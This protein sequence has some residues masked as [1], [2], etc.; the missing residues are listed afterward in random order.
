MPHQVE[1]YRRL[2]RQ[3]ENYRRT[4]V[5]AFDEQAVVT[6][7]RL[8]VDPTREKLAYRARCIWG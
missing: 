2:R 7:Q 3:L 1:A 6:L 8:R 4:L 5:L